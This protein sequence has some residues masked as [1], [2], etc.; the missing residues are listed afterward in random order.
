MTAKRFLAILMWCP[1]LG[2]T[3]SSGESIVP[4]AYL[5]KIDMSVR[6]RSYTYYSFSETIPAEVSVSGPG[7]L[8][9]ITRHEFTAKGE[10][11]LEYGVSM[12]TDSATVDV[13]LFTARPSSGAE[14]S[15]APLCWPGRPKRIVI[16]VPK[17]LHTYSFSVERPKGRVV[18]AH[19]A[20]TRPWS[21]SLKAALMN[22]Y[23]DNVYRYSPED[24]E[25][26]V[27]HRADE[28]YEM[29]TYDDFISSSSVTM[30]VTRR[31]SQRLRSRLRLKYGYTFFALN[32]ARNYETISLSVKTTISE[33]SC[34]QVSYFHVPRYL[35]RPYFDEDTPPGNS[36]V[37]KK[38]DFSRNLYSF[39][40][41]QRMSGS[42]RGEV[43]YERDILNY[44]P[45]FTEYDM[46]ANTFG[47]ELSRAVGSH[48]EGR[49]AYAL[50]RAEAKGY[51]EIGETKE[52]SDDSDISYDED[53]FEGELRCERIGIVSA[54]L[55]FAFQYRLGMRYFTTNKALDKDPFHAGRADAIHRFSF[56]G[57]IE[58]NP[59]VALIAKYEFQ[60]RTVSSEEKERITE[61]KNF[62]RNRISLGFE[63]TQ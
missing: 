28:R 32:R 34:V 41:G 54:P 33:G 38:C 4:R 16:A 3:N 47:F 36:G 31:F 56:V 51:D 17:G 49:F 29:E 55:S 63:F 19:F 21:W 37:Y 1:L 50:R 53:R 11:N 15:H 52:A 62:H 59:R 2:A 8:T 57:Q 39:R 20:M 23:D 18:T 58:I 10:G 45:F 14:Y 12:T 46:R 30:Y 7:Q 27:H 5:Q 6:G 9:V 25:D 42:T 26:F 61:V 35:I 44:N 40:V 13:Y 48:V 43:F 60:K 24:I 22:T